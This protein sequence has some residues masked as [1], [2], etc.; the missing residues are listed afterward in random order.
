MSLNVTLNLVQGLMGL[1]WIFSGGSF[2]LRQRI[3]AQTII[4]FQRT[5]RLRLWCSPIFNPGRNSSECHS[6][7]YAPG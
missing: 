4:P 1:H 7:S 5:Y 2:Y 6:E 3:A